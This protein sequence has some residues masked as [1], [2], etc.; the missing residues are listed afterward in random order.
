MLIM[1][2]LILSCQ[3]EQPEDF[4]Q[5][6]EQKNS[7]SYICE[8]FQYYESGVYPF[9]DEVVI[10]LREWEHESGFCSNFAKRN[11]TPLWN[12]ISPITTEKY[13]ALL[14]PVQAL[15]KDSLTSI[16]CIVETYDGY[17]S[18]YT[19]YPN[20]PGPIEDVNFSDLF[21]Y[22]HT[23]LYGHPDGSNRYVLI[24]GKFPPSP[25]FSKTLI[26]N[27]SCW[28][29]VSTSDGGATWNENYSYCTTT[30][31]YLFDG[32][33]NDYNW[34]QGG[35]SSGGNL[36]LIPKTNV[37]LQTSLQPLLNYCPN[38]KFVQN[39]FNSVNF[40]INPNLSGSSGG[41]NPTTNNVHFKSL[42]SIKPST[43]LHELFHAFQ[44]SR[45]YGKSPGQLGYVNNEFEAWLYTDLWAL[46]NGGMA[47][48]NH[49]SWSNRLPS[50]LLDQYFVW[51]TQLANN[52]QQQLLDQSK[53]VE[54]LERFKA[55]MTEYNSPIDYS[56]YNKPYNIINA[57]SNCK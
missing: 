4:I 10:T 16:I 12:N 13:D 28:V 27:T 9:V 14:V 23:L 25:P 43:L 2:V 42:S 51:L 19:Y 35:G 39:M 40:Y 18:F 46:L 8:F 48:N 57:F 38:K 32:V 21:L 3:K 7:S 44:N 1:V 15:D 55:Y 52:P 37:T 54:W 49:Q 34:D 50:S 22:F 47:A 53:F 20:T 45:G 6:F 17:F 5:S 26:S 29:V 33:G 30:F 31:T 56:D 41:Y 24:E 36:T 11:G